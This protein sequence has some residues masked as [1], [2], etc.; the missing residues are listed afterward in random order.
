MPSFPI[1]SANSIAKLSS[2]FSSLGSKR[3]F[4]S[5]PASPSFNS[6]A[7]SFA[8]GPVTSSA[9]FTF[10]SNSSDNLSATGFIEYF[11]F[12]SPFG[13]P[14]C[15]QRT[16][17]APLSSKYLIVGSAALILVSSVISPSFN[18]TL[19]S[20]RTNIFFPLSSF[21]S[22]SLIVFFSIY[23]FFPFFVTTH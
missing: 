17:F 18:G 5:S 4:S 7:I 12:T 20:Q 15:E 13:L 16:T 3:T 6:L 21:V 1:K 8:L 2:F 14:K 23:T 19:K 10:A 22:M 9:H 11:S